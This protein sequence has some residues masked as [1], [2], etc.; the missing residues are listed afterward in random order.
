MLVNGSNEF[1]ATGIA[2]AIRSA[3]HTRGFLHA[4]GHAGP[5]DRAFVQHDGYHSWNR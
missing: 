4:G 5:G 1:L 3:H 2:Y